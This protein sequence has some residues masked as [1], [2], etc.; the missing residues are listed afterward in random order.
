[1]ADNP[2]SQ[3]RLLEKEF[4]LKQEAAVAG[5][6][7]YMASNASS[8]L[9][10]LFQLED[11]SRD[12]LLAALDPL[13]S[14]DPEVQAVVLS[15][16]GLVN[17]FREYFFEFDTFLGPPVAHLWVS[18]GG[19]V[20]VYEIHTRKTLEEKQV[21]IATEVTTKS[22]TEAVD[23]DEIS[24]KI[25]AENARDI[26]LGVSASGSVD[27]SVVQASASATFGMQ[28]NN[29][30]SE[31]T[32]HKHT[33]RQS[34]KVSNEIRRNFKTTFRT[35][36]ETEDTS[37]RRY[38]LQNAT[39]DLVNFELR[40]KMRQV[41]VQVQHLG[42]QL[43]WQLYVDDPGSPL[44]ISTLVH[45]AQPADL[46]PDAQPPGMPTKLPDKKDQYVFVF[47]F[48][49]VDDEAKDD[50]EDE[51][52]DHGHD[53]EEDPGEGLINWKKTITVPPPQNAAGYVLKSASVSAADKVD[54]DEDAPS[55]T[56]ECSVAGEEQFEIHLNHVNFNDQPGIRFTIDL[57]WA[58]PEPTPEVKAQ[59]EQKMKEFDDAKKRA[60]HGAY[61]KAIRERVKLASNITMRPASDLREEERTVIFRKLIAQLTGIKDGPEPHLMAELIRAI[62]DVEK[63]LYYV[64]PEWWMPRMHSKQQFAPPGASDSLTEEDKVSWGGSK[65]WGRPNYLVTEDSE[66]AR[67]GASL[68]WMLQLDGDTHRN[69]FLNSPWVKAVVPIRPGREK[70]ALN[71]LKRAHVE[72]ADG[73]GTLYGGPEPDLK[74]KTIEQALLALASDVTDL[75]QEIENV[76]AT[77]TVFE[78]GFDPLEGGFHATGEPF[79]IFDQWI[80]VL[81][82]D[83]VVAV[84]VHYDPKTGQEL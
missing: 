1:V 18:P 68:G 81:P 57:V 40:R 19:S 78:H 37:S 59:Y 12:I 33:R 70:A 15:P 65:A 69:A 50:G 58:A 16:I 46:L 26:T 9:G 53:I 55:V 76:L 25:S 42:T 28:S 47:P 74:G 35:T 54:P 11:L 36:V 67:M 23:E 32:A 49:P 48:E 61:V 2:A 4:T 64:A 45:V 82:T 7:L 83:Q 27:F 66:P 44:G 24:T 63:M 71:W 20:E 14:F 72:D 21:E 77:E 8:A 39:E 51:D 56:A 84:E 30:T 80:E 38:L 43:C 3:V 75:G 31:E 13:A 34:E 60:A 52:Y 62:F 79:E 10:K 41:G 6:L 73:L 17:L 5:T 29:K 22:E